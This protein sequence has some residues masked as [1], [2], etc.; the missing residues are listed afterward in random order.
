MNWKAEFRNEGNDED[1]YEGQI[2]EN[3]F[4]QLSV[5]I[6]NHYDNEYI[7]KRWNQSAPSKMPLFQLQNIKLPFLMMTSIPLHAP[8]RSKEKLSDII[9]IMHSEIRARRRNFSSQIE[10]EKD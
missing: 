7:K 9:R 4:L 5:E 3:P 8:I 2:T 1:E 6:T 10:L